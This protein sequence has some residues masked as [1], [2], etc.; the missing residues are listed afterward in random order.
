[1]VIE[2]TGSPDALMAAI[3]VVANAGTVV[4]VGISTA[5]APLSMSALPYKELDLLG[6]RNSRGLI[7]QAAEF[8]ARNRAIAETLITHRFPLERTQDALALAHDAP[9]GVGK[10]VIT[11]RSS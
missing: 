9:D 7:P 8:V 5:V 1:V 2:A 3:D 4:A 10:T 11:V 6:S